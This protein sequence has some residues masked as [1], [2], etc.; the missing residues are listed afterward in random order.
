MVDFRGILLH[1]LVLLPVLS[2]LIFYNSKAF[3]KDLLQYMPMPMLLNFHTNSC[4][5]GVLQLLNS[6]FRHFSPHTIA[7]PSRIFIATRS[8]PAHADAS[9]LAARLP[10]TRS[11]ERICSV[12]GRFSPVHFHRSELRWVRYIALPF[13]I[14]F[15]FFRSLRFFFFKRKRAVTRC[16]KD[17]CF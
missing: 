7:T 17:G 3:Q 2:F 15:F 12:G 9:A 1:L 8:T 11:S 14:I 13:L 6:S 5:H 10:T 16:L 4:I